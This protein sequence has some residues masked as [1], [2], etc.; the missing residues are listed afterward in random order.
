MITVPDERLIYGCRSKEYGHRATLRG[1]EERPPPRSDGIQHRPH[2]V[3]AFLERW[4]RRCS[5][6]KPSAALVE[7]NE[8][9]E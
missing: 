4:D 8:A 7:A 9:G 2:I 3:H 6:G 5:I 1:P